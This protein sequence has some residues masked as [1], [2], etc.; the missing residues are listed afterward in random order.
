MSVGKTREI[1]ELVLNYTTS[2]D[3]FGGVVFICNVF[4]F[5]N[6]SIFEVKC[7]SNASELFIIE[8]EKLK[9]LLKQA[10]V[11]RKNLNNYVRI[12]TKMVLDKLYSVRESMINF[13]ESVKMEN[14]DCSIRQ[15]F[16]TPS[17]NQNQTTNSSFI[18]PFAKSIATSDLVLPSPQGF[19]T[20]RF[21]DN[22]KFTGFSVVISNPPQDLTYMNTTPKN[23]SSLSK[24]GVQNSFAHYINNS[25]AISI[26]TGM[27]GVSFLNSTT[28][29]K[30]FKK[31]VIS[32]N[33]FKLLTTGE[34]KRKL[35][36][37]NKKE[38]KWDIVSKNNANEQQLNSFDLNLKERHAK[39]QIKI[40]DKYFNK[41][42][43]NISEQSGD[44]KCLI[45]NS[46]RIASLKSNHKF[47]PINFSTSMYM[48]QK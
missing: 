9:I 22:N 14:N 27:S 44:T 7:I 18:K 45:P 39:L 35:N 30:A 19:G 29:S 31:C 8:R 46:Q 24:T 23:V 26:R 16:T 12:K 32:S 11:I 15:G 47:Q 37:L 33:S 6:I 21:K 36:L 38:I 48:K 4:Y 41:E 20:R 40:M 13:I 25:K 3:P 17:I 2:V 10:S 43:T 5:A 34:I 42:E 1:T 28:Q